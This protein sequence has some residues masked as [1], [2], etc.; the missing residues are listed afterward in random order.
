MST[1][2]QNLE[3][4]SSSVQLTSLIFSTVQSVDSL[5]KGTHLGPGCCNIFDSDF[6]HCPDWAEL[7]LTLR[8]SSAWSEGVYYVRRVGET[9]SQDVYTVFS[10]HT[11]DCAVG[12]KYEWEA[13]SVA[14]FWTLKASLSMPSDDL[15]KIRFLLFDPAEPSSDVRIKDESEG[16]DDQMG[17]SRLIWIEP[18]CIKITLQLM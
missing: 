5:V 15:V 16:E 14:L 13:I 9:D 1:Q 17:N 2:P 18:K 12:A 7:M 11:N 4:T 8:D 6:N 10:D 3:P